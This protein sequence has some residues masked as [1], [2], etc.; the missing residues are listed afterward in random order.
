MS[1]P[2]EVARAGV[3]AFDTADWPGLASLL[4]PDVVYDE[5][6]TRQ[7]LTGREA[8]VRAFQAWKDG[9]PDGVGVIRKAV[10]AGNAVTLE[11]TWEATH[12][13]GMQGRA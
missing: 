11:I 13:G 5:Y 9:F 7:H 2:L 10:A 6:A 1:T 3:Q 12:T 8:V 4:L